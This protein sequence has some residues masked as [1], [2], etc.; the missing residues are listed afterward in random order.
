MTA[1]ALRTA[2]VGEPSVPMSGMW[3]RVATAVV[4]VPLFVWAVLE[5]PSALFSALVIAL[6]GGAAW[7]LSRMFERA[8][9]STHTRLAVAAAMAVT[10]S[11]LLPGGPTIALAATIVVVLTVALS[12]PTARSVESAATTI[13][14]VTYVGWLL[15]HAMLLRGALGGPQLVLFLVGVTWAGESAAYIVGST[16]GRRKL[17]PTIS[18]GKT[19]EG[20]AAQVI[21]SLGVAP[22]LGA[23]LLGDWSTAQVLGAGLLLGVL[24]Q[25]GDLAESTIKRSLGTK[26][27]GVIIPGHGGVL[28]RLDSLLFNTSALFYYI[29][30]VGACS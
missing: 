3:K 15:G 29:T 19:V 17:A 28:D 4:V 27:T 13:F 1:A 30:I 5:G 16:L 25:V 18:P 23:W 22:L 2:T 26:D 7:E 24:G 9:R 20:A 10:A 12:V 6:S 11:F 21:V 8:E 14:T